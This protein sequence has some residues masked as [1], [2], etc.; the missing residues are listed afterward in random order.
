MIPVVFAD[1]RQ[2][3]SHHLG[4]PRFI[5]GWALPDGSRYFNLDRSLMWFAETMAICEVEGLNY[6]GHKI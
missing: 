6:Q 5:D 1:P 2:N 4:G 3:K